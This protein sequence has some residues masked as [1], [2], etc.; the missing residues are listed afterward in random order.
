MLHFES[1]YIQGAHPEILNALIRTNMT[2]QTGYGD[3]IWCESAKQKIRTACGDETADVF[4]LVGG[5]QTN[6]T[7]I[8]AMLPAYA[9][10]VSAVT[11]HINGHE[12]G[13]VE[14]NG[15][16]VLPLPQYEGKIKA[17]DLRNMIET[18]NADDNCEHMI[19]PGMVYV[20]H[21]TEYGT[22]YTKAELTAI[23]E[24]CREYDIPLF[25]DGARLGYALGCKQSDLCL[26][27]ITALCDV[28]YIGGTKC[29]ALC[30]EA[31]VFPRKGA[32]KRFFTLIKQH[33]ALLAKGR[34]LGVQFDTL[35]TDDLYFDICRAAV[36]KAEIIRTALREKGYTFF[37]ETVSNQIFIVLE[38]S[39]A[40][41]LREVVCMGFWEKAGENHTVY[42]IATSWA[43]TQND[44]EQL[45][46]IL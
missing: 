2:A 45:L 19:G 34:L 28:F 4:F 13:A 11:G 22:L 18:Y 42:R 41:T 10:V 3:D 16:K 24:V 23:S 14:S 6:A 44:V 12:A 46:N 21:P 7:V 35:F 1:D 20:S 26:Q 33:G 39:K 38:N 29:G 9:G 36:E 31:L 30:G 5:T 40:E 15:N 17:E 32:P 43:T 27:D 8:N 37:L 25:L